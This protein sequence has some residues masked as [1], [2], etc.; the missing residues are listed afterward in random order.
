[1]DLVRLPLPLPLP[2]LL[3]LVVRLEEDE[4][5]EEE[6]EDEG[7]M[8]LAFMGESIGMLGFGGRFLYLNRLDR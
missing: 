8:A 3:L 7:M 4:D 1:M 5:D 2:L 6:E